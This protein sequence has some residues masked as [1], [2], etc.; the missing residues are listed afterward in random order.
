MAVWVSTGSIRNNVFNIA[1]FP[2]NTLTPTPCHKC[3]FNIPGLPSVPTLPPVPSLPLL[4]TT[5]TV[6][7]SVTPTIQPTETLIPTPISK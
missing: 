6:M 5:C 1:I 3:G 2:T 7:P 4:E